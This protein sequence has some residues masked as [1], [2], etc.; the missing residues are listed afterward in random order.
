MKKKLSFITSGLVLSM[1]L[2]CACSEETK[3]E[4]GKF[5]SMVS[6]FQKP[7]DNNTVWTYYYWYNDHVSREGITRDLESM[8]EAGIGT[9]FIGNINW[10]GRD[11]NVPILSEAWWDAMVHA[12][13]EGH[14]L[15]ID[16]GVFNSPGWSQSGGPWIKPEMAM[17]YLT[18]SETKVS[19]P[20]RVE[21][22]L[23]QPKKE[24]QDTH[25]LAFKAPAAEKRDLRQLVDSALSSLSNVKTEHL[26]D[27]DKETSVQIDTKKNSTVSFTF[28]LK[29]AI[30][31]RQVI[32][33]QATKLKC[34]CELYATVSGE[35]K[36]ISEFVL[37]RSLLYING[38]PNVGP[39]VFG[40]L[41]IALPDTRSD[42]F[43]L[44]LKDFENF[45]TYGGGISKVGIS[46]VNISEAA[47][48]DHFVEKQ[49]GK[50]HP[51]DKANWDSYLW[52]MQDE[53]NNKELVIQEVIDIS[54]HVDENG[55]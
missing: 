39:M 49:L 21:V 43:K 5:R 7:G 19:G 9:V 52:D 4:D 46:E 29:E 50:M 42:H 11:G 30:T 38:G 51:T 28:Q 12:V 25:T 45:G 34:R 18:Y 40:E 24:F 3:V 55:K 15:G 2:L 36:L 1:F 13:N 16:I 17:R 8:I 6:Q 35:E 48:L 10:Q 22:Q 26:I 27:N 20:D 47:V 44:V 23:E 41:A 14:R 53:I 32:V 33:K 37:D 54:D 31:A